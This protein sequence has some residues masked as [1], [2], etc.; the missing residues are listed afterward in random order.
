MFVFELNSLKKLMSAHLRSIYREFERWGKSAAKGRS[1]KS[2]RSL[3]RRMPNISIDYGL[4]EKLTRFYVIEASF[5]WSDLGDWCE[6]AQFLPRDSEGNRVRGPV[7]SL[8]SQGNIVQANQRLI[9]LL[10]VKDFIVV[11]T[12]DA[13]LICSQD[14]AQEVKT[15][16]GKLKRSK[17]S[18]YL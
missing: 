13:L 17:W 8:K 1:E 12:R 10:G 16:V 9:A 5:Q 7:I 15:L 18:E 2:L 3:Y 14:H 4:M 6:A 11:D